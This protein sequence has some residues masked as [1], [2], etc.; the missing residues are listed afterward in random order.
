MTVNI[1]LKDCP[2]AQLTRVLLSSDGVS[3]LLG[4]LYGVD[5]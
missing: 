3:I 5:E 4:P 2:H 1:V